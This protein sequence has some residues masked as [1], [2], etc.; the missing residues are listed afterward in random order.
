MLGLNNSKYDGYVVAI[1]KYSIS[2]YREGVTLANQYESN[3]FSRYEIQD[4]YPNREND[5]KILLCPDY[6]PVV[7]ADLNFAYIGSA[8]INKTSKNAFI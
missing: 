1:D 3:N 8:N 4:L 6:K 2:R 7:L 5:V